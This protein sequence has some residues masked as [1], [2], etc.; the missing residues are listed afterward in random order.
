M[1][2]KYLITCGT[3]FLITFNFLVIL[4][5]K[6]MFGSL[7]MICG[8]IYSIIFGGTALFFDYKVGQYFVNK[9]K[10]RKARKKDE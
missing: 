3:I 6:A 5:G 7:G 9:I 8:I 2:D 10:E 1:E 4:I